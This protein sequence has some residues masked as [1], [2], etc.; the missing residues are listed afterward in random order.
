MELV[1]R[2]NRAFTELVRQIPTSYI[3]AGARWSRKENTFL[4]DL[5]R[6]TVLQSKKRTLA[7]S[8]ATTTQAALHKL[9]NHA[10]VPQD[11]VEAAI[12]EYDRGRRRD[13]TGG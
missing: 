5:N 10:G 2:L 13:G 1:G 4:S 12:G 3:P 9:V 6:H 11:A 8:H 7:C